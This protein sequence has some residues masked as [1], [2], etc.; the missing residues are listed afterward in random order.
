MKIPLCLIFATA[1]AG[2]PTVPADPK[3]PAAS[4]SPL[5][6]PVN[7]KLATGNSPSSAPN[8]T[9]G[10]TNNHH[11][12]VHVDLSR[13]KDATEED[14]RKL[15]TIVKGIFKGVAAAHNKTHAY[16][17]NRVR[18]LDSKSGKLH[19]HSKS[20]KLHA[21]SKSRKTHKHSKPGKKYTVNLGKNHPNCILCQLKRIMG[22]KGVRCHHQ[23][24]RRQAKATQVVG[25]EIRTL[26]KKEADLLKELAQKDLNGAEKHRLLSKLSEVRQIKKRILKDRYG[27][28]KL[29]KNKRGSRK[30]RPH[31]ESK[32]RPHHRRLKKNRPY[33]GL[34]KNRS[35]RRS[36]KNRPQQRSRKNR[37]QRRSVKNRPRRR[38]VKN[39]PH[40]NLGK[41]RPQRRSVKNRP[42]QRSR[43][44][45]RGRQEQ[46]RLPRATKAPVKSKCE[47]DPTKIYAR[48]KVHKFY[49]SNPPMQRLVE[50]VGHAIYGW[51]HSLYKEARE[52]QLNA[53]KQRVK[54][55]VQSSA[56]KVPITPQQK[57]ASTN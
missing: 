22:Q 26:K 13:H 40:Q 36:K 50:S 48:A 15:A 54:T 6:T 33:R 18:K 7:P 30:N 53:G 21:H 45:R 11:I 14:K 32:E 20:D 41:N 19:A 9:Q 2:Q 17:S 52:K 56:D 37:P 39:R 35:Q 49:A 24:R 10:S 8:A 43:Q 42:R 28:S 44:N 12:K 29:L 31:R 3:N 23:R 46:E 57:R 55:N 47:K 34:E 27:P 5:P 4:S 51:A 25:Q 16:G 1:F 38:S